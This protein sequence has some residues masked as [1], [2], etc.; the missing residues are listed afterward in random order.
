M[1][2][3]QDNFEKLKSKEGKELGVSHWIHIDQPMIDSFAK[4]TQDVQFIHV[5]PSR[6]EAE[7]K[8]GGTIAH[9]FLVLSLAS[10][11]ATEVFPI[12]SEKT[13]RINY[14]FNKV[15]FISPVRVGS[16]VRGR[17]FLNSVEINRINELRQIYDLSI[18][19][20]GAEKPAIVAE[21]IVLEILEKN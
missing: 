17:F 5:N 9:G 18:E 20:K 1:N 7:T 10:K 13:V 19:I 6:A 14:G 21:W 4:V 16:E 15:R 2:T 12:E 8:F 3:T 11:F